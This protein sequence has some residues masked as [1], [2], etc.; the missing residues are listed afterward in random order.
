MEAGND[1]KPLAGFAKQA[2]WLVGDIVL[3][4]LGRAGYHI[5]KMPMVGTALKYVGENIRDGYISAHEADL[6]KRLAN[7]IVDLSTR[8][9]KPVS[10]ETIRQMAMEFEVAESAIDDVKKLVE[11]KTGQKNGSSEKKTPFPVPQ[12]QTA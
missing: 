8:T 7:A 4:T 1:K 3:G 9:G 12:V 5:V 2:D 6:R 11:I 10:S